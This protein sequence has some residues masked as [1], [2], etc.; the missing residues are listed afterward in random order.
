LGDM[1][2]E[3]QRDFTNE[4][5]KGPQV[6]SNEAKIRNNIEKLDAQ[7]INRN[8]RFFKE[9]FKDKMRE[10]KKLGALKPNNN[11]VFDSEN[12]RKGDSKDDHSI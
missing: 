10:Q 5:T 7:D 6:E 8:T 3:K 12:P 11:N 4:L 1:T 9:V 2:R